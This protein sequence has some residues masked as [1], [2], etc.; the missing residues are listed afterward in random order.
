M[1]V[2]VD[3]CIMSMRI[4]ISSAAVWRFTFISPVEMDSA[5]RK[6]TPQQI[7]FVFGH[8]MGPYVLGHV[9]KSL[10]FGVAVFLV[11]L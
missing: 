8:E 9:V 5:I 10:T 4:R 11:L 2:E 6:L 1:G 3:S 7:M